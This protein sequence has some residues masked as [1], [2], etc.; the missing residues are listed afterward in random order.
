MLSSLTIVIFDGDAGS[1]TNDCRVRRVH[2]HIKHSVSFHNC[3]CQQLDA[4]A[5]LRAGSGEGEQESG[6]L[7]NKVNIT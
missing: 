7:R 1:G 5:Q 3:V 6:L 2:D 4:L